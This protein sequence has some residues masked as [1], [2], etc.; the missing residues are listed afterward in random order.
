MIPLLW[1]A[2]AVQALIAASNLPAHW[3]L[4]IG[5]DLAKVSPIVRQIFHVQH[6]YIAVLLLFLGIVSIVFAREI[7]GGGPWAALLALF[8]GA[9]L[10]VQLFYYDPTVRR[11]HGGADLLFTG[12]F[13]YLTGVFAV[14]A[15]GGL[16]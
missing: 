14:A 11:R 4:P 5:P 13:A 6:A 10:A 12:A 2:G 15:I 16:R 7:L 9:R 3:I 1:A 8:W